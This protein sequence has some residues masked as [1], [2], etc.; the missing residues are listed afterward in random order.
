ML[1]QKLQNAYSHWLEKSRWSLLLSNT[2]S[3]SP[4]QLTLGLEH[5]LS[6]P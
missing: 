2:G 6:G 5:G 3:I 1:S 4:S